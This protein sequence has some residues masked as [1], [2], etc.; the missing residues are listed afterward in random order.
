SVTHV[1]A[2]AVGET[3]AASLDATIPRDAVGEGYFIVRTDAFSAVYEPGQTN[4]NVVAAGSATQVQP[5]PRPNLVVESLSAPPD[6]RVGQTVQVDYQVRNVGNDDLN[7]GFAEEIRLVD[8]TGNLPTQVLSN[9]FSFR[10]IKAGGSQAQSASVVVPSVPAGQWRLELV[11]DHGNH[12]SE[13]SEADNISVLDVTIAAPDLMVSDLASTGLLQGGEQVSL[14]WSTVNAGAADATDVRETVFLSRDGVVS[15]DD[16]KLG[17]RVLASL[18]AGAT[19]NGEISFQLPVDLEG[20]WRL[21]VVTDAASANAEGSAGEANNLDSL[22]VDIAR[23]YYA[24]LAVLSV[25]APTLVIDDPASVTV[26]WTVTNLGT[27][28]GRT[29]SWTDRV[30]YTT[31]TTIGDSDDIVLGEVLHTGGL[32]VGAS[33]TDSVNYRFGP[34]LSRHGTVVVRTD[35][36]GAVWENGQEA[37]NE[38]SAPEAMDVMPIPYADLVVESVSTPSEAFS[39]RA[40]TVE[41]TVANRGIGITDKGTWSDSVWLSRNVEGSGTR[42]N[43]GSAGHLG[44]MAKDAS[45][46]RSIEVTLPQGISGQWYLN[47]STGGPFEFIYTNNNTGSSLAV[48]VQLSPS[49]DLKV[50]P[51]SVTVPTTAQEGAVVDVSWTVLN[52]G[53]A[54]A[55]GQWQDTVQLVD[56]LDNTVV[57]GNFTYDRGLDAGKEYTR[58]EQVRLPSKIQGGY[59]LRVA[60][61]SLAGSASKIQVY[62]HGAARNNNAATSTDAMVVRLNPRPD[63]RVSSVTAPTNVTAGTTAALRFTV[64]NMGAEATSGQWNDYVYLSLDGI[65]SADDVLLGSVSSGAALAPGES[66]STDVAAVNIPIR[67]RGDANMIVVADGPN[68]IDEYPNEGNNVHAE[69]FHIDPVPFADLVT[70]DV[71]APDQVV[72]GAT[73]E[74]RYKVGNLGSATTLGDSAAVNSWTDTVWLAVDKR[75]PSPSKGDIRIGQLTHTGHLAVDED[76]LGTLNVQIPDKLRSGQYYITVWSD[77][78]DAILEDTLTS[79]INPDDATQIDNNNYKAREVSVLGIT[80]PDLVV[81]QVE[82]TP[83]ATAGGDYTFSYTVQNRGDAFD[84]VWTDKVWLTDNADLSQAKVRWLLGEYRQQRT[85]GQGESYTTAQTIAL[86]L[87]ISAG[88]IVVETDAQSSVREIDESNNAVAA[89]SQVDNHPA[90]LRVTSVVTESEN[91]SGEET[92]VTWTVTNFGADVWAGT[93]GWVDNIYFSADPEFIPGRAT[94]IGS[95]VHPQATAFA[96]GASYT[97]TARLRLPPGTDG[98]YFIYVI[99]DALHSQGQLAPYFSNQPNDKRAEGEQLVGNSNDAGRDKLYSVSVFEGARNDNNLGQGTLNVTYREPDLQIDSIIVSNPNP[100]SGEAIT[101]TWTVTN[102]G[103]RETR[104]SGWFDGA[105]LS[106]DATLDPGDYP[107][108]DRGTDSEI[109]LRARF[110]S[111]TDSDGKPRFLQPGESY[112]NSTT[113]TLP[114]SISGDFKLIVMADVPTWRDGVNGESTVRAGLAKVNGL[115]GDTD[116]VKEFPDEG[117]NVAQIALPITLATPPD[118][119]VASV[120]APDSVLAGQAFAVAYRVEN[121]GGKTPT[122]QGSWYDMVYLSKDRFLDIDKDRYLGYV[123]HSGGLDVAASYEATLNFTAPRDLEGPYYVFV[124]TDPARAWGSGESGRV[125]EFGF[126]D[127]NNAAAAQPMLIETPPPADLQVTNVVVP[128]SGQVGDEVEITFTVSNA[129]INPAYGRWTDAL[130]LSADN[131]WDLSDTLLGKVAHVGDVGADGSYTGSLKVKLPPLKDGTWRVIV[132][133][134]LFNEVFEGNVTY[135]ETGLNL[136]PGEANNRTASSA[137]LNVEVPALTVGAALATTL[138][139]GEAQLYKVSVAAG[140]TLRVK[141]DANAA[142]GANELYIRWNDVPNGFAFDAAYSNPVSPD[143]EVLISATKAG[144]YYVLLRPRQLAGGTLAT[145]RADLLPLAITRI[146]PDQGGTGDDDH[147]WVSMDIFGARFAAGALVKLS[148]PGEF[149]IEPERWQVLDATHIRAVFDL[150]FVPHGLYDVTVIN[151]DGQRITEPYRYLVER[152]IETDVTIGIGGPRSIAPGDAATYSVSLQSLSNVDTS[153]VRFDVGATDMGNSEYVLEGLNLPYVVFGANVGGQPEGAIAEGLGNTQSYGTTPTNALRADIPW[154]ALDGSV[155]TQGWNLA[156]GYAFDVGAG[157]FVGSTFNVQTYPGLAEWINYDFEG[158]RAKLYA[159][160][161]D[162]R[163]QGLLAGGVN[164]L[165][166][167]STGLTS[168]FLSHEPGVHITKLEALAMPFRFDTL[169]TATPLTRDEFIA[170]Q[171]A[172]AKQLRAAILADTSAPPTLSVL[173]SDEA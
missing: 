34:A 166:K 56:T 64:A 168:K 85:L 59:W 170:D 88:F 16:T 37:N 138:G 40:I 31:N 164:D 155:N 8:T 14:R 53:E 144:D 149:E 147:R 44:Q 70:S 159:I 111:L 30:V 10:S 87:S 151:P 72:H 106:R 100:S 158:L 2:L 143:Q 116:V 91:V 12:V 42:H 136:P 105:H 95:V 21:L 129:S 103:T 127:N 45:Y 167:I 92:N 68:R 74:V 150:R 161:P 110:T 17:E 93:R 128:A 172:H 65:V 109:R 90:D 101:A 19:E 165:D 173:A 11:V 153:Y 162:W 104:V 157:G 1:G 50:K 126:E 97:T 38:A 121:K 67:Y 39:G 132:R 41:W 35:A 60:T 154:A 171:T 75:R 163:E 69:R 134:D 130:Y 148:R 118:L 113:F 125:I 18:A 52:D 145:L 119:Q 98:Q 51:D 6:W 47:V 48:P 122:D 152:A 24:D 169:G 28:V 63:L 46:G 76:Y 57:L 89:T 77:S 15:T 139:T 156:P 62:E 81:T 146:T 25:G 27:G 117:N 58:T 22:S 120:T 66:Y 13:S 54:R 9:A 23:D 3:Y 29:T 82:G 79:N 135:T 131:A 114:S 32:E 160:R 7:A 86:A 112:T 71:V 73:V 55:D 43:L 108:V 142:D 78:Y 26:E 49:P 84:A 5:E 137:T 140:E 80:P 36:T 123:N 99:T 133:P 124:V 96:A 20:A 141:L 33:Y 61:N 107:V 115:R 102:R 94:Q 83:T 4:N